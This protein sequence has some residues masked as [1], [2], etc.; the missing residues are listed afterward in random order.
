[1]WT[2]EVLHVNIEQLYNVCLLQTGSKYITCAD[3]EASGGY[4]PHH[5]HG[6]LEHCGR[7]CYGSTA[8]ETYVPHSALNE[9]FMALRR[10]RGTAD[11]LQSSSTSD[12]STHLYLR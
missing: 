5:E 8:V 4:S 7:S 1:M 11:D 3:A 9:I 2:V 6:A 10:R 12:N